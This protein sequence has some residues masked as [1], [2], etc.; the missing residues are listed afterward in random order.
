[1]TRWV[2]DPA[3]VD[4]FEMSS[5]SGGRRRAALSRAL[6]TSA[7]QIR[8]THRPT[9]VEVSGEIPQG[10]YARAEMTRLRQ[11]LRARLF[12]ALEQAV[13]RHLRIPGR[14]SSG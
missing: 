11:E 12:A 10:N 1:M 4:T 9:G 13:A 8:L 5:R 6:D 14:P 3:E 2:L 7:H